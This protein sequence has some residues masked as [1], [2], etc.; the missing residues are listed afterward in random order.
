MVDAF[1]PLPVPGMATALGCGGPALGW[2]TFV[3]AA[4]RFRLLRHDPYSTV[5]D[6]PFNIGGRPACSWPYYVIPSFAAAMVTRGAVFVAMLFLDRLPR[7][8][9]PVFKID[10]IE[11]VT[12]D[13]LFVAVEAALKISTRMQSN[14]CSPSCR[15]GRCASSVCRD[16]AAPDRRCCCCCAGDL[17]AG[18]HV[19]PAASGA[20][21]PFF[22][23]AS[24]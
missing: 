20:L 17:R 2:V 16:E 14:A 11:G 5:V 10:G 22:F 21:G 6:Y 13:R 18:G 19:R 23:S 12:Q 15:S 9:H 8:N 1:S 24:T 7:L 3:G 4:G